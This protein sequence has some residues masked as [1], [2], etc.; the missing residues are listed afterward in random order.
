MIFEKKSLR[1]I[2]PLDPT[3]GSCYIEPACDYESNDDLDCIYK[4]TTQYQDWVNPTTDGQITWDH[5]SS[6]TSNFDEELEHWKNRL[7]EVNT[8]SYNMMTRSLHCVS[9]EERN[10]HTYD[11]LNDVYIFLDAF[12]RE[13][14]EKQ[15]FQALDWALR[16]TPARWW[17]THKGRFDDWRECRRMMRTHFGKPKVRMTNKYDEKE[18]PCTHLA[19]WAEDYGVKP[20]P[21]WV[22]LFCHTLDVIPMKWYLETELRHGTGE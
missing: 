6:Y 8:L 18:Y 11:G 15:R 22:H 19:K 2:V 20:Q 3:E 4:I 12:D 7:H 21:K 5:E 10:L 13:V 1:V 17:H 16:A 9:S 14:P